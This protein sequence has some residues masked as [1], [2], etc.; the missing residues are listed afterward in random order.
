MKRI[1]KPELTGALRTTGATLGEARLKD[2]QDYSLVGVLACAVEIGDR[3]TIGCIGSLQ[4]TNNLCCQKC[5][6]GRK[7]N[8]HHKVAV[9]KSER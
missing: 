2:W 3:R 1:R 6:N 5:S 8:V 7:I 9:P 4:T